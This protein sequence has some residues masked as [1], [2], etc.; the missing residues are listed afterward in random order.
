MQRRE[1]NAW[2]LVMGSH[3]PG[4]SCSSRGS[5]PLSC[6]RGILRCR[7]WRRPRGP[8]CCT[9]GPFPACRCS[10]A[11]VGG[12]RGRGR[13]TTRSCSSSAMMMSRRST[14]ISTIMMGSSLCTPRPFL[15]GT[16]RMRPRL[17]RREG[18][19]RAVVFRLSQSSLS[20]HAA[21]A[22]PTPSSAGRWQCTRTT[23]GTTW[24]CLARH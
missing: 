15:S 1:H 19:L 18:R 4:G 23:S 9:A 5:R 16:R 20:G 3:A 8:R 21:S 10:P 6:I 22:A 17:E 24:W 2:A 7:S 12:R 14:A 13:T 11:R